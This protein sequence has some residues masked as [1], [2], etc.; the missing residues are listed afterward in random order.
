MDARRFGSLIY[1]DYQAACRGKE[2]SALR[3]GLMFV[4][5]LLYHAPLQA[6]L[7]VRLAV[8]GPRWMFGFWRS[9]LVAKHSIDIEGPIEVGPGLLLP[10]PVSIV[11][12]RGTRI[13]TDVQIMN[14]VTIGVRPYVRAR[15]G[16]LS[17]DIRDRAVLLAQSIVVGP[18]TVGEEALIGARAWIDKD[19]PA[20]AM[21]RGEQ[22][23]VIKK[24]PSGQPLP[25]LT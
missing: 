21:V 24:R 12:A 23:Q 7:L 10:H 20:G 3:R 18:I 5:R 4:P 25:D 14:H 1:S 16:R 6:T 11:I 17:P 9:L 8:H 22:S 2:E 15:E 19:V 13:G